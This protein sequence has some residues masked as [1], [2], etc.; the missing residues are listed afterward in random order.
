MRHIT[1]ATTQMAC[2]WDRER[3]IDQA[4]ALVRKAAARGANLVVLQELFETPYFCINKRPEHFELARPFDGNTTIELFRGL[5]RELGIVIPVSFFEKDG[6]RYFNA[7]TVIDADGST[8]GLYR[9]SHIP[10]FAGYEEAYYFSPGDTGFKVFDTSFGRIGA[11]VCWDQWFPE[12]ARS[13]AMQGAEVLIYPT[14]IGSEPLYPDLDSKAHW[15]H[16][17]QGHAAANLVVVA[18]S[19]RIGTEVDGNDQLDFYGGSFVADHHGKRCPKPRAT[20]KR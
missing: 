8:L 17:M 13:M 11:A 20:N 18:A 19:N 12:A 7:L 14:A 9:K 15:Q 3:N 6:G 4:A 10:D 16:T 1:I 2:S 5:A